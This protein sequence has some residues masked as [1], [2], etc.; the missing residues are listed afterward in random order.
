LAEWYVRTGEPEKAI[1]HDQAILRLSPGWLDVRN[2]L[3]TLLLQT[4]RVDE[5]IKHLQETIQIEPSLMQA[6]F[7]LARGLALADRSDEA[8]AAAEK[9]IAVAHAADQPEAA[10]QLEQ[11]LH[12][13][14]IEVARRKNSSSEPTEPAVRQ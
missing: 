2:R 1:S 12:H 10:S 8:I 6:H 5:A 4:D 3:A 9:G 11:W 14:R 13:Y 7:D